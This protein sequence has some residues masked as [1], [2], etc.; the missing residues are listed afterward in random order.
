MLASLWLVTSR[1]HSLTRVITSLAGIEHTLDSRGPWN[2]K[3]QRALGTC[4][5]VEHQFFFLEHFESAPGSPCFTP[6][7]GM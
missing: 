5:C 3:L 7:Q 4:T 1:L 2:I 6:L